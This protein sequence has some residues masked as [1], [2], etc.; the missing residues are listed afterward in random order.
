M[1]WERRLKNDHKFTPISRGD[2]LEIFEQG[3]PCT[4]SDV[5]KRF[6]REDEWKKD[7]KKRDEENDY[8]F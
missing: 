3:A 5:F 6:N 8:T 1:R 7:N 2:L 4:D